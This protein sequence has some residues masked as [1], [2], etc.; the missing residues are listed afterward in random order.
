MNFHH[1]SSL[2]CC[3]INLQN[4]TVEITSDK[5]RFG[6]IDPEAD[7]LLIKYQRARARQ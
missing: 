7:Y 2:A 3:P 1:S 4:D 5:W 6:S